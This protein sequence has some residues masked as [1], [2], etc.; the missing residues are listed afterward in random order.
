MKSSKFWGCQ[1]LHDFVK[2]NHV[3]ETRYKNTRIEGFS[4]SL[5]K[6]LS[7]IL[8]PQCL[9]GTFILSYR[10][11][12]PLEGLSIRAATIEESV[13]FANGQNPEAP[14][15]IPQTNALLLQA[16]I[17]YKGEEMR[18]YQCK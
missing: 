9:P 17:I 2:Q 4:F 6:A 13:D 3:L 12:L 15:R 16:A 11:P 18:V 14:F 8:A 1:N 7:S 5:R 10:F